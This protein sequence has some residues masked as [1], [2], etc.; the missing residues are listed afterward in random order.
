MLLDRLKRL[1]VPQELVF[2]WPRSVLLGDERLIVEQ[3]KGVYT[4][5]QTEIIVKTAC[6]LLVVS[7]E[8]LSLAYYQPD[9]LMVLGKITKLAYRPKGGA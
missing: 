4:C 1:N 8:G 7:G 6:G 3:H 9:D 5:T 2:G